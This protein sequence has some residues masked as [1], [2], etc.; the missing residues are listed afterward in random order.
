MSAL[1]RQ[2]LIESASGRNIKLARPE[3]LKAIA[4]GEAG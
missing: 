2:G 4:D 1:R 3:A